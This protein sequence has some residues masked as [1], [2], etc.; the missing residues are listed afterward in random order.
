MSVAEH[1]ANAP[2]RVACFILTISDSRTLATETSGKAIAELLKLHGH[3][4]V[5]REVVKDEPADVARIVRASNCTVTRSSDHHDRW[6][7][8][9]PSRLDL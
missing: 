9:L 7:R 6:H 4:V 3:T 1:K 5:G 8:S 2:T